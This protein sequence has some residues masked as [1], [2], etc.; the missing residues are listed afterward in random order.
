MGFVEPARHYAISQ[1]NQ[2]W[3]LVLDADERM[4]EPLALKLAEIAQENICDVVSLSI[5]YWY[6]GG[7]VHHGGFSPNKWHRF[8]R[9]SAY[10]KVYN[11][12]EEI[13]HN[14]FEGLKQ[15]KNKV[16]LPPSFHI[17]HLAYP[18][19][20]KYMCKTLGH[21]AVIEAEAYYQQ[22]RR[23]SFL[24]MLG[25]PLYEIIK[26]FILKG[27][28]R[29]GMRGFI[30]VIFRAGYRFSIWANVWLLEQL[31]KKGKQPNS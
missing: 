27:G 10:L 28:F 20:E 9:K 22:G 16:I 12:N 6:F 17:L 8:F 15:I 3:V 5:L 11:S 29:D 23:F 13:V 2:E 19:I 7:W 24:R 1:A 30:L 14:N 31:E 26:R 18:T 4:T 21:Y 25:E